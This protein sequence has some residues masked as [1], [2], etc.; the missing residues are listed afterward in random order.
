MSGGLAIVERVDPTFKHEVR[1]IPGADKLTLCFQCGMCSSDCPVARRTETFRPRTIMRMAIL[2]LKSALL[3]DGLIWL[4][5]G[6]YACQENCPQGVRPTDVIEALRN[7]A[8]RMGRYHPSLR[9]KV[10][11]IFEFGRMYE[12]TEFE[13]EMREGYGLPPVPSVR[14]EELRAILRAAGVSKLLGLGG[15]A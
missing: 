3:D 14:V 5:T 10:E 2:G 7:L 15:E 9:A 8:V 11:P 1:R 6:C 12:I 4:C 13:N